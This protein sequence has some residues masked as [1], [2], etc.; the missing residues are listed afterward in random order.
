MSVDPKIVE[1]VDSAV[2]EAGQPATLA[3]RINAWLEAIT[4]GNEDV[5]DSSAA[6]RHLDALYEQTVT[7]SDQV[8]NYDS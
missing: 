6:G 4:S 7:S 5:H 2:S 1:A 8:S 3:R